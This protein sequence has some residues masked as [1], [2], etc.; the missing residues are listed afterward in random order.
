MLAIHLPSPPPVYVLSSFQV[1]NT[2]RC[3]ARDRYNADPDFR[4]RGEIGTQHQ[5]EKRKR[6]LLYFRKRQ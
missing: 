1:I 6:D 5:K 4:T 3:P 2:V